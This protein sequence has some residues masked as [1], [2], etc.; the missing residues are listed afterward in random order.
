L[1]PS[2][3]DLPFAERLFYPYIEGDELTKLEKGEFALAL[4]IDGIRSRPFFAK[5]LPLSE[6]REGSYQDLIAVSRDRYTTPRSKVDQLFKKKDDN[7]DQKPKGKGGDTG[8]FSD[9]FR[10]IF[11]KKPGGPNT[12][13]GEEGGAKEANTPSPVSAAPERTI[14]AK[15]PSPARPTE[16]P[17]D[18]LK[19]MLYVDP[20]GA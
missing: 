16:I 20:V 13:A 5:S 19:R 7:D 17:E 10:S 4:A 8:S 11:A 3:P 14:R 9:T 1:A 2:S 15:E 12:P 6:R 18:E